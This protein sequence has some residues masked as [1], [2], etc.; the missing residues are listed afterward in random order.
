MI[1]QHCP[2]LLASGPQ[3]KAEDSPGFMV[4]E[5]RCSCTSSP[6]SHH[7]G[8]DG[9]SES[10]TALVALLSL[11]SLSS[12]CQ[13]QAWHPVAVIASMPVHISLPGVPVPNLAGTGTPF[14]LWPWLLLPFHS[15]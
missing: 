15:S 7:S 8:K 2:S 13:L 3:T 9:G 6:T 1:P 10:N 11:P 4:R 5:T 12:G 14:L